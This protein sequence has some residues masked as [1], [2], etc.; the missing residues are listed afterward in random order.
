MRETKRKP[1]TK[2][3]ERLKEKGDQAEKMKEKG[4]W[5]EKMKEKEIENPSQET[6]RKPKT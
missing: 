6:K 2:F 3:F 4:D 1:K 5:A